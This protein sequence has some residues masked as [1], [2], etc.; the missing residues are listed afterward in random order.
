M[1]GWC[2]ENIPLLAL[3]YKAFAELFATPVRGIDTVLRALYSFIM[4]FVVNLIVLVASSRGK[5][6]VKGL[7][8]FVVDMGGFAPFVF[9]CFVATCFG[10]PFPALHIKV[11]CGIDLVCSVLGSLVAGEIMASEASGT[12][13]R[14]VP[15]FFTAPLLCPRV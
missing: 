11:Y 7:S 9:A 3:L 2:F 12:G 14:K 1:A 13:R 5:G 6:L 10:G 4:F 15:L 8:A